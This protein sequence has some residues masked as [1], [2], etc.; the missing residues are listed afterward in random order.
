MVCSSGWEYSTDG[1]CEKNVI[2]KDAQRAHPWHKF[3]CVL[4]II[5]QIFTDYIFVMQFSAL[6]QGAT[7]IV[8]HK[9]HHILYMRFDNHIDAHFVLTCV[10]VEFMQ[11]TVQ[12]NDMFWHVPLILYMDILQRAGEAV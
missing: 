12:P 6:V 2:N 8:L 7:N 10:A 3:I 4:L 5:Q 11:N 9:F 1:K